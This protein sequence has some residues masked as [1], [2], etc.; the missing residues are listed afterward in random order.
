[1]STLSE[2]ETI[3]VTLQVTDGYEVIIN[4]QHTDEVHEAVQSG[5]KCDPNDI[6][7]VFF[8]EEP[9][10]VGQTFLDMEIEDNGRLC[11]S[12]FDPAVEALKRLLAIGAK[13]KN[14]HGPCTMTE[15]WLTDCESIP[16]EVLQLRGLE[17][18]HLYS[19]VGLQSL[20]PE[21]GELTNLKRLYLSNCRNLKRI[22]SEMARL[23]N[24]QVLGLT[25]CS[26]LVHLPDLHRKLPRLRD[27]F[28]T[29]ASDEVVQWK[30]SDY[31]T[32]RQ[33]PAIAKTTGEPCKKCSKKLPGF[34]CHHH[35]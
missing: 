23:K 27:V 10:V 32:G 11:V 13:G 14:G 26:S 16:Q 15:V 24:L 31:K 5:L 8:G 34:F 6:E 22:P 29:G 35:A 3:Q 2:H 4:P 20:V 12:L 18:L 9:L 7:F 30:N 19:C 28:T 25:D 17:Y 33:W 21:I 1:M